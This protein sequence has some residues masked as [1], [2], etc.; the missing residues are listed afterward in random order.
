MNKE[1]ARVILIFVIGSYHVSLSKQDPINEESMIWQ[2]NPFSK[3]TFRNQFKKLYPN[4]VSIYQGI[5]L[6]VAL[7]EIEH[8]GQDF[9]LFPTKKMAFDW[10]TI[11]WLTWPGFWQ[12]TA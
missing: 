3:S 4:E 2:V 9:K 11:S 1:V 12:E 8:E 5:L 6:K 7:F 10:H